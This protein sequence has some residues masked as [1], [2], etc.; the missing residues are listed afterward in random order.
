MC[1]PASSLVDR[2]FRK[3]VR[4]GVGVVL[5]G[6]TRNDQ[7]RGGTALAAGMSTRMS[8]QPRMVPFI[9]QRAGIHVTSVSSL[10][11][12]EGGG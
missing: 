10:A 9:K 1:C 2:V 8:S 4:K 12:L 3:Q 6:D 11:P 5:V 7:K